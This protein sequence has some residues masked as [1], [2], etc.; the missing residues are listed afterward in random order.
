MLGVKV[1]GIG[2]RKGLAMRSKKVVRIL[3]FTSF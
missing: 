3:L 2:V 1:Q